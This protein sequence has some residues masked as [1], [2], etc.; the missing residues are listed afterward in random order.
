MLGDVPLHR[1]LNSATSTF[2][3]P[4][5][6]EYG[7]VVEWEWSG[8]G[9]RVEWEWSESGV[10]GFGGRLSLVGHRTRCTLRLLGGAAS[11]YCY[12]Y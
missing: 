3:L 10:K 1:I 6:S 7:K 4:L 12:Y 2:Q 11:G 5:W 8:S 9:V